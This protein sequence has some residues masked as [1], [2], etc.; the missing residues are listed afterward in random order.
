MTSVS[1][2]NV[3]RLFPTRNGLLV[4]ASVTPVHSVIS[5][6][7]VL[8]SNP[9]S[10]SETP[11]C[12]VCTDCLDTNIIFNRPN[13]NYQHSHHHRDSRIIIP[14]F[15]SSGRIPRPPRSQSQGRP[16][17]ACAPPSPPPSPRL[18]VHRLT[19]RNSIPPPRMQPTLSVLKC[20][21]IA[22]DPLPSLLYCNAMQYDDSSQ[23][24]LRMHTF[25]PSLQKM[26]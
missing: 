13:Q 3:I 5:R 7:F 17:S 18:I 1:T 26:H 15:S 8:A 6:A 2:N 16:S 25:G 21:C 12:L 9:E 14:K 23:K 19:A 20:N 24:S 11:L 10:F 4:P 22:R